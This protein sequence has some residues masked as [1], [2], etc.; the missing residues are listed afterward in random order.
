MKKIL[1]LLTLVIGFSS[2]ATAKKAEDV[3]KGKRKPSSIDCPVSYDVDNYQ[4]KVISAIKATDNCSK[5]KETAEVC[6]F[7]SGVDTEIAVTA[8]RK[9]GLDFWKK[10]S[11]SDISVYDGLQSRC[12]KKWFVKNICGLVQELQVFQV[13][14]IT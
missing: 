12:N 5:A 11:K 8:E 10:L 2:L 7:G 9:C 6:A 14:D 4:E 3:K 13:Y 1:V